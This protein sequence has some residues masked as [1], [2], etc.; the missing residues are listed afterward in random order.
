MVEQGNIQLAKCMHIICTEK[1]KL[2][3]VNALVRFYNNPLSE[4]LSQ[5]LEFFTVGTCRKNGVV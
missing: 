2:L 4:N 1:L 5:T 3:N